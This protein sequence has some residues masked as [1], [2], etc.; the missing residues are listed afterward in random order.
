MRLFKIP[1]KI[2]PK[3]TDSSRPRWTRLVTINIKCRVV[4]KF[5]RAQ[6]PPL[7]CCGKYRGEYT[8]FTMCY[9]RGKEVADILLRNQAKLRV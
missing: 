9:S 4:N 8:Y 6:T 1:P 5:I 7:M 3:S 2:P